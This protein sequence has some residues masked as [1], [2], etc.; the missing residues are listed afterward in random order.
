[1]KDELL[2]RRCAYL[3]TIQHTFQLK[4]PDNIGPTAATFAQFYV[5]RGDPKKARK[6]LRRAL[7][8][9]RNVAMTWDLSLQVARYGAFVDM[10]KARSLLEV[11]AALPSSGV[12]RACLS[13]FDA[14]VAQR[15]K[16]FAE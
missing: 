9:M 11:R 12:A 13:L 15:R 14:L 1:M 3:P 2:L 4:L 5:A 7:A 8:E 6:L 10:P 16:D